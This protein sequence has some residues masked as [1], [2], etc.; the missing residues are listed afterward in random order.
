METHY[1]P[2]EHDVLN[3]EGSGFFQHFAQGIEDRR[4]V[5]LRIKAACISL[6]WSIL[7]LKAGG[8]GYLGAEQIQWLADDLSAR[9]ASTP[10]IV[11]AHMPLW[12]LYPQWRWEPMTRHRR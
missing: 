10:I 4:L 11:L 6:P 2:G 8:L 7:N 9:S 1:V 5:R 12:A 3:D